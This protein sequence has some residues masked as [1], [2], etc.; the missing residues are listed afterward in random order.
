[1]RG[2]K[3]LEKPVFDVEKQL[4]EQKKYN[5]TLQHNKKQKFSTTWMY[6]AAALI[7][8]LIGIKFFFFPYTTTIHTE[9]GQNTVVTLPDHSKVMLNA[10][11]SLEY[12]KKSFAEDKV[13]ELHGEAF[14]DVEKGASF[15]V[16]TANGNIT[17]LGTEFNVYSR[18]KSLEVHCFEGKVSV[19]KGNDKVMLTA[20]KGTKYHETKEF[21]IFEI[22]DKKSSWLDGKSRFSEVPL[23]RVIQELE[24]QYIIKIDADHVDVKRIFTGFFVHNNLEIALKTSFDPMDID[25]TFEG[26]KTIVLQNK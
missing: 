18:N 8:L 12:N 14:F 7:L 20:G 23:E 6:S 4:E 26:K 24:R 13:V 15:I 1:M 25:Y 16:N 11:S 21:S 9:K 22:S 10:D 19:Q 2:V 5:A 17:V 3:R